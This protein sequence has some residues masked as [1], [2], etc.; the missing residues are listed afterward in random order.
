MC[1]VTLLHDKILHHIFDWYFYMELLGHPVHVLNE[2]FAF[3]IVCNY[4]IS[5]VVLLPLHNAIWYF[6]TY[7]DYTST[8]TNCKSFVNRTATRFSSEQCGACQFYDWEKNSERIKLDV[9]YTYI[10]LSWH[11]LVSNYRCKVLPMKKNSVD[12]KIVPYHR[13]KKVFAQI[14][15]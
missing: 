7:D 5:S 12:E 13:S 15:L 3:P 14:E 11:H 6:V 9:L 8:L 10:H 2:G 4:H 1:R